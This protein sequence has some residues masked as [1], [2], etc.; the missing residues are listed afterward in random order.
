VA[1]EGQEMNLIAKLEAAYTQLPPADHS[2]A[3]SLLSK[4]KQYPLTPKQM[5][6]VGELVKAIEAASGPVDVPAAAPPQTVQVGDFANVIELFEIAGKTLKY[7]KIHLQL[8]DGSP[9]VMAVAG[10]SSRAPGWVNVSDG[11]PYGH[12]QWYGRVSPAGEWVRGNHVV[13]WTHT[14]LMA[15]LTRFAKSP[16]EVALEYGKLTGRCCFCGSEL[17]ADNSTEIG[18]GPVCAKK[19]GL[20]WGRKP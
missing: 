5:H 16:A 8:P 1:K 9:I 18:Y 4:S 6:W 10:K 11:K 17:T 13:E 14:A 15:L 7:P 3:L 19:W 20:P 12:N 2:F